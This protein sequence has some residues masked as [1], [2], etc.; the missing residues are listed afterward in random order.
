MN[1]DGGQPPR[2]VFLILEAE[3]RLARWISNRGRR[4]GISA[5]AAGVLFHV[6]A[7]P[8]TTTGEVAAAIHGSAAGTS[9]LL[10]RM[11]Q[12]GLVIR[13]PDPADRRTIRVALGPSGEAALVD[14]RGAID[15]LN[16]LI[17]EGF[18]AEELATVARWLRH[19]S[20]SVG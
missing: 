18:T 6:A 10:A 19:V 3:R 13:K 9:G 11:E 15:E 16:D 14:I 1:P 7:V 2:L 20:R 5:P 12:S 4:R 17:T 8:E